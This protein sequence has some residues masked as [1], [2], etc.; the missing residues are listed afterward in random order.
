[1]G[2]GFSLRVTKIFWNQTEVTAPQHCDCT[3]VTALF[4][5][6]WSILCVFYLNILNCMVSNNYCHSWFGKMHDL[7]NVTKCSHFKTSQRYFRF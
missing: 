1:M 3:N 6:K 4:I 7:K 5:L 2:T